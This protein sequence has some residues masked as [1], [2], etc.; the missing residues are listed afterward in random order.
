[1]DTTDPFEGLGKA[2]AQ[3][4]VRAGFTTQTQASDV[5]K[6]DKG[7]LSRWENEIPRPTLENL[8]RVLAGYGASLSDLDVALRGEQAAIA[9]AEGP[10]DEEL[11]RSLTEAIRR[12]EG[13][14][15]ET[16]ER[17]ERLE[18][19]LTRTTG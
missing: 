6:I 14:Q 2:L 7:Q 17:V 9:K 11:I 8:G 5:L 12:V 19:D 15:A 18:K 4:R 16:E 1:M 10:T 3:L 13:R